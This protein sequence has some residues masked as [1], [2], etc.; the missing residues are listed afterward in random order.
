[1]SNERFTTKLAVFVIL[2]DEA[3]K[4]LLHQRASNYLIGYWDFPSGHVERG[5]ELRETAARELLEE[6]G[7]RARSQDLQ[8]IHIDHYSIETDYVN[9]IFL[10]DSWE[11]EPRI[12]E[13]EKCTA[14]G[15]FAPDKLPEKCVNAVRAVEAAGFTD[16]LTYSVTTRESYEQLMHEPFPGEL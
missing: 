3:G 14:I 8:L 9:F 6:V 1:M 11:G 10:C 4:I 5:E 2:R 16:E 7:V 15:W 12:C 13:P